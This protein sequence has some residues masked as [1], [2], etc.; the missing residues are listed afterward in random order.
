MSNR[1][2]GSGAASPRSRRRSL[3][4]ALCCVACV[5]GCAA[6]HAGTTPLTPDAREPLPADIVAK[7][8]LPLHALAGGTEIHEPELWERLASSR[9]ICFGE[10]HDSPQHH[11]AQDRALKELATRSVSAQRTLA[12]GFEMFQRPYQAALTGLVS[13]TL[14]EAQFLIDSQYAERW[15]FDFALYRPLLDTAREF[16]LEAL[17]L[18]APKELTRKIGRSGLEGLDTAERSSLP[19]LDLENADHKSYFTAAM[20]DHPLPAGAPKLEDMYAAQVVWDETMAQTAADWLQKAGPSSQL[21][22]VAG[23]GHCHRT[24]IPARITRRTQIPV[25]SVT[26]VLR[27]ELG[28]YTDST[29]YDWLIVLED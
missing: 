7:S 4:D 1:S 28:T 16:R 27:S 22:L 20:G 21:L 11:S 8:A 10:Q 17:A 29:R 12:V 6:S 18:N 19:E 14:P 24:A 25:L 15:G 3:V 5:S 23:A 26:P 13:G 2:S 9:V